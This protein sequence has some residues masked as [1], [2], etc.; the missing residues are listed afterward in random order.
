[1]VATAVLRSRIADVSNAYGQTGHPGKLPIKVRSAVMNFSD[2][3]FLDIHAAG[4]W[5]ALIPKG[6]GWVLLDFNKTVYAVSMYHQLHCL[7][8]ICHDL[9]L[10]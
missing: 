2:D 6:N 5:K 8:S 3:P 7:N 9:I 10:S 4:Q 1:M